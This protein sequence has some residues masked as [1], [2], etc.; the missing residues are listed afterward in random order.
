MTPYRALAARTPGNRMPGCDWQGAAVGAEV[1]RA[2]RAE[3]GVRAA[4]FR[5][6][7]G[8][9]LRLPD[10]ELDAAAA[11]LVLGARPS[12]HIPWPSCGSG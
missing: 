2:R 8:E 11:S 4:S 7:V 3:H 5:A 9:D 1:V 10:G 6:R 12:R